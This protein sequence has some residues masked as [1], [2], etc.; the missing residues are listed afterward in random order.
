MGYA[1]FPNFDEDIWQ[2]VVV[3]DDAASN[4]HSFF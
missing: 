3:A 4:F 2:V 1:R